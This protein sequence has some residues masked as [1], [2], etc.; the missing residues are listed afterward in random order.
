M[1][2]S[3]QDERPAY[4]NRLI[5]DACRPFDRLKTFPAVVRTSEAEASRL[6]ARW[7]GLFG[8]D[9][10]IRPGPTTIVRPT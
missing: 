1:A 9:G 2:Y 4:N 10:K 3:G 5:I 8:P 7:P 6:R